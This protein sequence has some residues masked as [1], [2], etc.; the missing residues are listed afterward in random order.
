M[1]TAILT[2]FFV[3]LFTRAGLATEIKLAVVQSDSTL[4]QWTEE[5]ERGFFKKLNERF[6]HR[7]VF[8]GELNVKANPDGA[9]KLSEKILRD[10][11]KV[12]FNLLFVTDDDAFN[13]VGRR[14]FDGK[15]KVV[16]AR[17]NSPLTEYARSEQEI[18]IMDSRINVLSSQ[19]LL[20]NARKPDAT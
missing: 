15:K 6:V 3:L 7:V 2:S 10:L 17:K 4:F 20:L 14:Y 13:L 5:V 19:T 12:E 1:K 18:N 11:E 16:F 9:K 8:R